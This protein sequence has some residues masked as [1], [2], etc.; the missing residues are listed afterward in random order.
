MKISL[1]PEQARVLGVLLEKEV[2]TPEAYPLTLNAITTGCNQ[3]S[4]RDPVLELSEADVQQAIDELS[5]ATLV[6]QQ[7]PAGGRVN[8]YSHRLT[9]RLFGE[10]E[11]S[12]GERAVMGLLLL[13]GP[14]TAGEIRTRSARLF[15]FADVGQVESTLR[16]LA[17][18]EDGPH[19]QE[20]AR[21]PGRRENRFMHLFC[22][23]LDTAALA[24]PEVSVMPG[25]ASRVE[26][27]RVIA[28]EQRVA[29]LE[30]EL[31][32]M[33]TRLEAL[34]EELGSDID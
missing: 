20:L 30:S 34:L 19:V 22:G 5:K 12:A 11:F 2:T 3:K 13:R 28:L 7:G 25:T 32:R 4:N 16:T 8:R 18:R 10:M 29:T 15:P 21:Q 6:R 27:D 26:S 31:S 9:N 17:T 24:E 23:A 33:R 14:Q 1:S